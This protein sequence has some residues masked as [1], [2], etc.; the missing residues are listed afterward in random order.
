[1]KYFIIAGEASGDIHGSEL[2]KSII[3]IDSEAKFAFLGGDLMAQAA[4]CDPIIHYRDMAY[5]GFVEVAKHLREILGF[6]GAAKKHIDTFAPDAIILIDYPS[7][8]LKIAEYS[9]RKGIKTFYFISPKV[10]AWKEYRV[11]KIKKFITELYS[12]LPF[13]PA[14]FAKHKYGVKYVGN[15]TVKEISHAKLRFSTE[16]E[17]KIAHNLNISK[18][19][20]A[21]VPGSRKKE[22]RDNL[23]T[24]L[25]AAKQFSD[26]QIVIAGAPSISDELYQEVLNGTQIPVLRDCS[27]ELVSHSRAALVTSGTATLE[28]AILNTPQIV[29]YRMTGKKWMYSLRKI[30]IKVK[31]ISLPNL[32]VD[33]EIIPELILH[34]CNVPNLVSILNKLLQDSPERAQMLSGYEIMQQFLG[35]NDCTKETAQNIFNNISNGT[36]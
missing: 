36:K 22:I 35:S 19:I 30:L 31:Y 15:P 10:W 1:M 20:I 3:N 16:A 2:I 12:I 24:M 27:F 14:F 11:K 28:T 26:Y 18:Q 5:M 6:L 29:C 4:G 33:K 8:N 9:Y 17:F 13:E 25:Q 32:I 23:P 34:T 21:L 7:F